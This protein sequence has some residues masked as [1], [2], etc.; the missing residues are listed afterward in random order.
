MRVAAKTADPGS[1]AG[2][3]AD[4]GEI[5]RRV[6][7][8]LE[9]ARLTAMRVERS[10]CTAADCWGL[11]DERVRDLQSLDMLMQTLAALRDFL[12]SV[13]LLAEGGPRIDAAAALERILL[14]DMRRRLAG[15][16]DAPDAPSGGEFEWL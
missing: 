1:Q 14:A 12:S 16:P 15:E 2:E 13:A 5:C 6:A 7:L 4:L 3:E 10:L 8:E 11:D 9:S